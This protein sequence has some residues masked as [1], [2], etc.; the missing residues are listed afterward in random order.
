MSG[1]PPPDDGL[2]G[3]L[4]RK[5]SFWHTLRAVAWSFFGI[6]R[7]SGYEHDVQ[8]LN[9]LHVIVA[10]VIGA[11]LFVSLLVLLVRWVVSSG[12]ATS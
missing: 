5:G 6:R 9:P 10:G 4:Q 11:V 3:A 12:V 7:G 1:A 8:K 2:R